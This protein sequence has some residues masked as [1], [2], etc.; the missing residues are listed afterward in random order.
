MWQQNRLGGSKNH[1]EV[2]LR[3]SNRLLIAERGAAGSIA[4]FPPPH[5][6]FWPRELATNLG[7]LWL[8]K[9]ADNTFGFGIRQAERERHPCDQGNFA[10]Y[11]ARPGTT[12]RMRVFLYPSLGTAEA[13]YKSALAFTHGDTYRPLP[14]YQVM[15]HH[16][17]T[18]LGSRL[19][20]AG[21]LDADIP[22]LRALRALGINIV[23]L[24]TGNGGGGS[25]QDGL[26]EGAVYRGPGPL[27]PNARPVRAAGGRGGR[28]APPPTPNT[29]QNAP[30][31]RGGG[32]GRG[33]DT[34][35]IREASL[36]G[37]RRHSDVD[38][39]VMPSQEAGG[40][41]LGGHADLLFSHPVYWMDGPPERRSSRTIQIPAKVY[42]DRQLE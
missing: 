25:D 7:Y 21:S 30:A 1:R 24:L 6:F 8:R 4:A 36:E 26:P 39:L 18:N 22:D 29:E 14:G 27:Q 17:H 12:Q 34:L 35:Q 42:H 28:G 38:F 11:S 41:W 3:T 2:P 19:L 31:G 23:S 40:N 13:N 10:L 5:T 20:E 15:N 16:Y 33:A 37:A 32:G 9:D